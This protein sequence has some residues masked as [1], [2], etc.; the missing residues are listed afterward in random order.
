MATVGN[1]FINVNARTAKFEAGMKG[2]Q[3]RIK[4]FRSAVAGMA[5]ALAGAFAVGAITRW[6]REAMT[7]VDE[8]AK[9]AHSIGI[10]VAEVQVFRHAAQLA[11]MEVSKADK[12]LRDMVRRVG[13]AAL[14]TGEAA[15]GLEHL[16]ISASKLATLR[17]DE[18]F[19]E[20][21]D[22][23]RAIED[24]AIA[25]SVAYKIFGRSGMELI[26]VMREGSEGMAGFRAELEDMDALISESA[27]ASIEEANDAMHRLGVAVQDL[28]N[29]FA[30]GLSPALRN[31][32]DD[33]REVK[34]QSDLMEETGRNIGQVFEATT[35]FFSGLAGGFA[36][37]YNSLVEGVGTTAGAVFDSRNAFSEG[38]VSSAF[39]D[40]HTD[41]GP[42]PTREDFEK[43]FGGKNPRL[44]AQGIAD[45]MD[46]IVDL[47]ADEPENPIVALAEKWADTPVGALEGLDKQISELESN[48]DDLFSTWQKG[49]L[50]GELASSAIEQ[51]RKKLVDLNTQR[52]AL[53]APAALDI[54][55]ISPSDMPQVSMELDIP[56]LQGMVATLDTA[57]GGM[58]V[59]GDQHGHILERQLDIER[60]QLEVDREILGA[61]QQH[62]MMPTVLG[63][64]Q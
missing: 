29:D 21:A 11:G 18:M 43:H 40:L 10:T 20:I 59:E 23:I 15:D 28:K 14:G 19:D 17:A 63:L 41:F 51:I 56:D 34:T 8:M 45:A 62:G 57:I 61:I 46:D 47:A 9:L 35:G 54:P 6:T 12:G 27:A 1:L 36:E 37:Q 16:G 50:T 39:E 2:A 4:M 42:A 32:A 26:N 38:D 55:D 48:W 22:S 24:P 33:M 30:V 64:L 7:A 5:G 31:I 13:E 49:G 25:G 52:D 3:R 53:L 44:A 60:Q 58:K